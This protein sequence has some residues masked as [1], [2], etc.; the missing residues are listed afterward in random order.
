MILWLEKKGSIK[1]ILLK[2]KHIRVEAAVSGLRLLSKIA[3]LLEAKP[4]RA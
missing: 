3:V 1:H 2:P 4:D